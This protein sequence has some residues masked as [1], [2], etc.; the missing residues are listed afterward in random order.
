MA[1]IAHPRPVPRFSP[2]RFYEKALDTY[3]GWG[4][5]DSIRT[6]EW[7]CQKY[8]PE[9]NETFFRGV[10]V[11]A[12]KDVIFRWM[13]QLRV[14]PYSY[15]WVDNAGRESPRILSPG[16]ERLTVGQR[17]LIIFRIAEFEDGESITL[18]VAPHLALAVG[19]RHVHVQGARQRRRH[20]RPVPRAQRQLGARQAHG[21]RPGLFYIRK[22]FFPWGELLMVSKQL[23][24]LKKLA[25]RQARSELAAT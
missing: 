22:F 15:D 14:A 21:P 18:R 11:A 2:R 17:T 19:R 23:K 3:R 5:D 25:E 6:R 9:P 12:P 10:R 20:V 24:T 1:Q 8:V 4:T 13:C 7:E 16:A